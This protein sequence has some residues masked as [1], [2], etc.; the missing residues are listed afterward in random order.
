MTPVGVALIV[1]GIT[2]LIVF[3]AALFRSP[4]EKRASEPRRRGGTTVEACGGGASPEAGDGAGASGRKGRRG[5]AGHA[6]EVS[7]ARSARGPAAGAAGSSKRPS[8]VE[9]AA[10]VKDGARVKDAARVKNGARAKD[11]ALRKTPAAAD[12]GQVG[13]AATED[14][15]AA[16][17]RSEVLIS[18]SAVSELAGSRGVDAEVAGSRGVRS[19]GADFRRVDIAGP[20]SLAGRFASAAINAVHA[21]SA[22]PPTSEPDFADRSDSRFGTDPDGVAPDAPGSRRFWPTSGSSTP[23]YAVAWDRNTFASRFEVA[24]APGAAADGVPDDEPDPRRSRSLFRRLVAVEEDAGPPP[25]TAVPTDIRLM[26]LPGDDA[27]SDEPGEPADRS[28]DPELDIDQDLDRAAD[29]ADASAGAHS[30]VFEVGLDPFGEPADL[31]GPLDAVE[32]TGTFAGLFAD[33]AFD[34]AD[35]T[36]YVPLPEGAAGAGWAEP[37]DPRYGDRVEG[38]VRP[39]YQEEPAPVS[40]EYWTPVPE[41]TYDTE[42]GWPT[43]V[44]RLPGVPP[45]PPSSGFDIPVEV[46][47]AQPGPPVPQWPPAQPDHRIEVPRSWTHRSET[48]PAF[49]TAVERDQ[50]PALRPVADLP[51]E[52]APAGR[53]AD[54]AD[55]LPV[56]GHRRFDGPAPAADDRV[57]LGEEG[58][59]LAAN[60]VDEAP[61]RGRGRAAKAGTNR[62][63][64][65]RGPSTEQSGP[66]AAREESLEGPI[67]AV[68]DLPEAAMPDLSWSP[69]EAADDTSARRPRHPVAKARRRRGS[70][71]AGDEATQSIPPIDHP[72]QSRSR[73]RPRPRPGNG[74]PES[75]STVYV[76]RHAAEPS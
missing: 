17:G 25:A 27:G 45:Y 35:D 1:G 55:Y 26:S 53:F 57:Y 7:A 49:R 23:D 40:G 64:V 60:P 61:R 69:E 2:T 3:R 73:P 39:Q 41:G 62:V 65:R 4:E 13:V 52:E 56:I 22:T 11:A 18:R 34:D 43:P 38:W 51:A 42:Y 76:S 66:Y 63:P 19:E 46:A 54:E 20:G 10:R 24:D 9:D 44:E 72:D 67:W 33:A 6:V 71:P 70:G 28:G 47:A 5:S 50:P 29:V 12:A 37:A 8:R 15:N 48:G 36:G 59:V 14:D 16:L 32:G 58:L 68:P 21:E 74:Q 31:S 30:H 75:R